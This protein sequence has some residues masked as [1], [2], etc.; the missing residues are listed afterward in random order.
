MEEVEIWF[1]NQAARQAYNVFTM[2]S[3]PAGK[4]LGQASFVRLNSWMTSYLEDIS[5]KKNEVHGGG[6][7]TAVLGN[8]AVELLPIDMYNNQTEVFD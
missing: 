2:L 4:S 8:K 6:H 3:K 5:R 7:E 1:S